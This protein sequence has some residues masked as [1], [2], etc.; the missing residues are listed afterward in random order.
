V[1]IARPA[2]G[3]RDYRGDWRILDA[4]GVIV[5][6]PSEFDDEEPGDWRLALDGAPVDLLKS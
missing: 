2:Q 1:L 4:Q 5:L 3:R 6:D